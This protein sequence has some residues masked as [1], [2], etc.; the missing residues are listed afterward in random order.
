MQ[1]YKFLVAVSGVFVVQAC[2]SVTEP[3]VVE[4]TAACEMFVSDCNA[5][6]LEI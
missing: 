6:K 2:T 5:A 3:K 1:D 4:V